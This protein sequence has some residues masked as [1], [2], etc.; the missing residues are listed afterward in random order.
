M[1]KTLVKQIKEFKLL[2][3]ITPIAMLE[4]VIV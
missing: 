4:E 1:L 2:S 3:I